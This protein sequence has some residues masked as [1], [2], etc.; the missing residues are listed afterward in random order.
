M[1][2]FSSTTFK[3]QVGWFAH[4]CGPTQTSELWATSGGKP[5]FPTCSFQVSS[6]YGLSSGSPILNSAINLVP[7]PT[8]E[9]IFN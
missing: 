2:R 7:S 9:S 8:R 3:E 5:P 1:C 6:S 4:T